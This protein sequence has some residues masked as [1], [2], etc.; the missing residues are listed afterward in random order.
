MTKIRGVDLGRR[1]DEDALPSPLKTPW[2]CENI[3]FV[4]ESTYRKIGM[5]RGQGEMNL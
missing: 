2:S 4:W 3:P 5:K 1:S